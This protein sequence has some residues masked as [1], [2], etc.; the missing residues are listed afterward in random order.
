MFSGRL[1][2]L[3]ENGMLNV[4]I[5]TIVAV[6][7]ERYMAICYP[8]KKHA[9]CSDTTAVKA[10][11]VLW[12]AGYVCTSPFLLM[13]SLEEAHFYD[14]SLVEVCSTEVRE[15][16]QKAFVIANFIVF[17]ALPLFILFFIYIL[18]IRQ[19]MS[20]SIRI[21]N[22]SDRCARYVHR[23]R[24]QV[25]RMLI[26]TVTLFFV[27]LC[28]MRVVILWKIYTPI[29]DIAKLGLE[30]Y[31]GLLSFS[32][33]MMYLNSSLNPIIYSLTS[34]K[35]KLAFK[36][37]L[38]RYDPH[39]SLLKRYHPASDTTSRIGSHNNR[40]MI[41]EFTGNRTRYNTS[42]DK[43]SSSSQNIHSM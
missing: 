15:V 37:V 41:R 6:T 24:K 28:P 18:I 5:L 11:V 38:R 36:R 39:E 4:S 14:G 17:F 16:W 34:S 25:V 26:I 33:I 27:T 10:I 31:L 8:L 23:S 30:G 9:Y 43:M 2:P 35:F 7:T 1:V 40:R 20:D 29:E 21:L 12:F 32:R 3:L 19:L 13:T 42:C 22:K